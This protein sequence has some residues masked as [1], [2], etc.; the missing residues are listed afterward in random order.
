MSNAPG[1]QPSPYSCDQS[2]GTN[3][4]N[5]LF[6]SDTTGLSPS[7]TFD[8]KEF[9]VPAANDSGSSMPVSFRY[10]PEYD[11]IIAKVLSSRRFP[12]VTRGD[13]FRHAIDRHL[14]Y[15]LW[16]SKD[17][18]I[19]MSHI[20]TMNESIK[21]QEDMLKYSRT[22]EGLHDTVNQLLGLGRQESAKELIASVWNQISLIT[23]RHW[24]AYFE[25]KIRERYAS[26]IPS[27]DGISLF[28]EVGNS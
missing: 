16:I 20:D 1:A 24:K 15:L 5:G 26:L 21:T 12:Y 2:S 11:R 22:I 28:D 19:S 14:K 13:V 18:P 8:P 3:G 17:L 25:A 7:D 4:A 10:P 6:L 23:D 9:I 27:G